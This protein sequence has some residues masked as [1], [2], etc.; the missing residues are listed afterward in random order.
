M[1]IVLKEN[2]EKIQNLP[3]DIIILSDDHKFS[4]NTHK[5]GYLY[6]NKQISRIKT[7]NNFIYGDSK[8]LI[9]APRV[10]Y[11]I[12]PSLNAVKDFI[13]HKNTGLNMSNMV[14]IKKY[15]I[16]IILPLNDL[17]NDKYSK[18]LGRFKEIYKICNKYNINVIFGNIIQ[19][20]NDILNST[21][22]NDYKNYIIN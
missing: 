14:L 19:S 6:N 22:F 9:L 21:Q 12:N 15:N 2:F 8:N 20:E 17:K 3:D 10:N 1:N 11:I 13:H 18:S 4:S 7:N 5:V 16:S